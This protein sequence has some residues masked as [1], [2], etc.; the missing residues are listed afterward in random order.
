MTVLEILKNNVFLL[1]LGIILISLG[2]YFKKSRVST[3]YIRYLL[4]FGFVSIILTILS[5]IIDLL[6]FI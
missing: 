3:K 6:I 1:L 4:P 5:V 2:L